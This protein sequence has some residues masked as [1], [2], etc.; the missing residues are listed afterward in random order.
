MRDHLQ[1]NG[2]AWRILQVTSGELHTEE[3][4]QG[5]DLEAWNCCFDCW[6]VNLLATYFQ[7]ARCTRSCPHLAC[8]NLKATTR[9]S[10]S[11]T[12]VSLTM[13][14]FSSFVE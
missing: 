9:A 14:T 1:Q 8:C 10:V 12:T 7:E 11:G 5:H 4:W 13:L 3:R 6:E 2:E